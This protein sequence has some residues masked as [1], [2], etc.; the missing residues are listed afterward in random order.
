[1][2]RRRLLLTLGLLLTLVG[3]ALVSAAGGQNPSTP[4]TENAPIVM[5]TESN[6]VLVDVIATDKKGNYINDL[7]KKDF[8]VF[9]DDAEQ[10]IS[11]FSHETED[12]SNA[13]GHKH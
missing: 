3:L 4:A 11:T 1:M 2:F 8:H 10:P 13:P 5:K 12:L 6:L 7:E 9:Q